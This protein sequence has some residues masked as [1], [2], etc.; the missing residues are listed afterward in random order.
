MFHYVH[1]LSQLMSKLVINNVCQCVEIPRDNDSDAALAKPGFRALMII[2]GNVRELTNQI[3]ASTDQIE[4]TYVAG[5][6]AVA[7]TVA[8][9]CLMS[10]ILCSVYRVVSVR[11]L[12]FARARRYTPNNSSIYSS[13]QVDLRGRPRFPV[14]RNKHC[15]IRYRI[16][17]RERVRHWSLNIRRAR[18]HQVPDEL[19]LWRLGLAM[20]KVVESM[21]EHRN[22]PLV[23][24][25]VSGTS[26]SRLAELCCV[27]NSVLPCAVLY[28]ATGDNGKGWTGVV[29][30]LATP[31]GVFHVMH[32]STNTY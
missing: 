18:E 17:S 23:T 6:G 8:T 30:N 14:P 12:F 32:H 10:C 29:W 31:P 5:H 9:K 11:A 7:A 3:E 21:E 13:V 15:T 1:T 2:L 4:R 24:E 26:R 28:C 27:V 20:P 16:V 25:Q 19:E 22:M